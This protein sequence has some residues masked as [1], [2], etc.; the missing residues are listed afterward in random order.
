MID[1]VGE[2]PNIRK[3]GVTPWADVDI[4]ADNMGDRYVMAFKPHPV[5]TTD[6]QLYKDSIVNEIQRMLNAVRRNHTACDIA[7]KDVSTV[8]GD[9]YNLFRWTELVMSM[10]ERLEY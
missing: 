3:I 2:I 5:F 6:F 1:I 10:V 4:A 8:N 7:L 9:P